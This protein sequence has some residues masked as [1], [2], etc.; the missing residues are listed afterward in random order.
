MIPRFYS[1][2]VIRNHLS[3]LQCLQCRPLCLKAE[4]RKPEPIEDIRAATDVLVNK[5]EVHKLAKCKD[6]S[7]IF[8]N[9]KTEE[10]LEIAEEALIA[11]RKGANPAR[12]SL[13]LDVINACIRADSHEK[14]VL[15]I[16]N[17]RKFGVFPSTNVYNILMKSIL[18]SN[19]PVKNIVYLFQELLT[20]ELKLTVHTYKLVVIG[21]MKMETDDGFENA[22][23]LSKECLKTLQNV[24]PYYHL[25]KSCTEQGKVERV[26]SVLQ[27]L[28]QFPLRTKFELCCQ[29]NG[30]ILLKDYETAL[31]LVSSVNEEKNQ[32]L[33]IPETVLKEFN[34]VLEKEDKREELQRLQEITELLEKNGKITI[35]FVGGNMER[36]HRLLNNCTKQ[37]DVE[38]VKSI[39]QDL[40]QFPPTTKFELCCQVNGHIL[41]KD[42]ETALSLVSSVN[43]EK[44]QSLMIPETVL[45]DFN[46]VLEK[47]D[48]REELQRLQEITELLEKNGKVSFK[49]VMQNLELYYHR[50]N[51]SIK[52]GNVE[53][54]KSILEYLSQLPP[55]NKFKLCCKINGHILLK[56]YET[57]LS[58]VSSV[59]E[60]ENQFLMIP[61][62]ILKAFN[63]VLEKEDKREELQRLQEITE[64][65]EKNGKISRKVEKESE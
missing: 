15:I 60:E 12:P 8:H 18:I 16:C 44:N 31:S 48:K 29:V 63:D 1:G 36:H 21:Y 57:A 61:E 39:L 38:R 22:L 4:R 13:P 3:V 50:L 19:V 10:D 20:D 59:N 58:L 65:L 43:E 25:L 14:A 56:D 27:D 35:K 17:K 6:L 54:V 23:H 46:D 62:T 7:Q 55:K 30:H 2:S 34:D 49:V 53:R 40:S 28:S 11:F 47:E 42:Y 32:S 37:G 51:N 45:K 52:Q 9:V 41:L 33:M 26:K 64:L 24:E 5:V